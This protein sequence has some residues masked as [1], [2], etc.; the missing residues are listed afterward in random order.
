MRRHA[1]Y[2]FT[3]T[4]TTP[5]E[6]CSAT[7]RRNNH[8]LRQL[9]RHRGELSDRQRLCIESTSG[10][11][12][13]R[14]MVG[15]VRRRLPRYVHP[16]LDPVGIAV[17]RNDQALELE[18][19]AQ[20][21]GH[22]ARQHHPLWDR[23]LCGDHLLG[24]GVGQVDVGQLS[25]PGRWWLVERPQDLLTRAARP[26]RHAASTRTPRLPGHRQGDT[27]AAR[28]GRRLPPRPATAPAIT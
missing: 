5:T 6:S 25:H 18:F 9:H 27:R 24:L 21:H 28:S 22:R 8:L 12:A 7:L 10:R 13:L 19:Q 1:S 3:T 15:E 23:R 17:E 11:F 2:V 20:G 16:S 4:Q 26:A 14:H